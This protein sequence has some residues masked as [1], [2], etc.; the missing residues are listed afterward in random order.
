MQF[1]YVVHFQINEL[2]ST[3]EQQIINTTVAP[4]NLF[5]QWGYGWLRATVNICNRCPVDSRDKDAI[6]R[7]F[8]VF[9][10]SLNRLSMIAINWGPTDNYRNT[11]K[12][13]HNLFD[14]LNA[15]FAINL[16]LWRFSCW[17]V[18]CFSTKFV[19]IAIATEIRSFMAFVIF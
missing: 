7:S 16:L 13:T 1:T 4:T 17:L 2:I 9:F 10:V 3:L 11:L 8:D 19:H 12:C 5:L 14:Q 6:M 18:W 15:I